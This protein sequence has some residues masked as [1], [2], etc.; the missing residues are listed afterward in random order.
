LSQASLFRSG[1][2][3]RRDGTLYLEGISLVELASKLGTPL[4]VLSES[5]IRENYRRLYGA[6]HRCYVKTRIYYAA[7]ANTNMSVLVIM[8][9]EGAFLDAVSPG[10]IYIA[11]KAGFDAERILYTGT[12]VSE[13]ELEYAIKSNV[14]INVDSLSQMEHLLGKT[15]PRIVSVRVNPEVGAGHHEHCVTGSRDSKFGLLKRDVHQAYKMAKEARVERFGIQM[16]IGSGI[17]NVEPYLEAIENLLASAR[18]VHEDLGINFEFIDLGG[19]FGVPY[20]PEEQE[21]DIEETS[22]RLVQRFKKRVTEYQLGEPILCIEPGRY[23]V[24]DGGILLTSVNSVKTTP[25]KEFIG[26]DAGFNTL[27][28][29]SMYDAYHE[30]V[31]ANTTG[32]GT[33]AVYDVV[34]P[35]CESGDCLARDRRLE[36]TREGDILA[37][38]NAGAYGYAMTSQYNSRPRPAEVLV[39]DGRYSVVRESERF[40]TLTVG[41]T[42]AEWLR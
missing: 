27:I 19:G 17:L 40:G 6:F 23:I 12:S 34:G 26:V 2:L 39:R 7:K 35:L 8:R 9:E 11:S 1:L 3:E 31:L 30:I 18:E 28:R 20:R 10:E 15:C 22:D 5:R 38:L 37:V 32:P 14:T 13:N 41:Q 25:F 36:K 42:I 29:P 24:A 4:Y 21:L 33:E 16:H